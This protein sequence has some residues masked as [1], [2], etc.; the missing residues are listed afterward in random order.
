MG[1]LGRVRAT[2]E[3]LGA[4]P[5]RLQ[6]PPGLQRQTTARRL[7]GVA[8][9]LGRARRLSREQSQSVD[10]Y[11][12]HGTPSSNSW[13]GESSAALALT[14][15]TPRAILAPVDTLPRVARSRHLYIHI[16]AT[17]PHRRRRDR[18]A[19]MCR[20][21]W[22]QRGSGLDQ[23]QGQKES[24]KAPQ[25]IAADEHAVEVHTPT[26]HAG[27]A[28]QRLLTAPPPHQEPGDLLALQRTLGNQGVQR[29]LA[30]LPGR[31]APGAR[32]LS[33]AVQR[34]APPP[35]T[36]VRPGRARAEQIA[37][38]VARYRTT[39]MAGY[40][41]AVQALEAA[42]PRTSPRRILAM[43]R[44][45]YYG[46]PWSESTTEQWR[47]VLPESPDMP[48]PRRSAAVGLYHALRQSQ[49]VDGTD[50]G[51]LLA[52]LEA[53]LNPRRSVELEIPGPNFVVT[54]PNTEFATWGGDLGSAAGQ[55]VADQD[56]NP[57]ARS[58][59]HYFTN[60]VS[61]ADL[62]GNIDAFVIQRGARAS[63]GL[64]AL[65]GEGRPPGSGTPV[66][67]ILRQYYL[68]PDTAMGRAHTNRYRT[69]VGILG[70]RVSGRTITNRTELIMPIARRVSSFARL[71][72]ANEYRHASLPGVGHAGA[73]QTLFAPSPRLL[74]RL[75]E[76]SAAM[77]GLFLNWLQARL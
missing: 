70:G 68:A 40:V 1:Q 24:P 42:H 23:H 48:D 18:P 67:E 65:L 38:D 7:F 77:V 26:T 74:L 39:T 12:R 71:W 52:G 27:A 57:P 29:L 21:C 30:D 63:G 3:E 54:M 31:G 33:P 53:L 58:D 49:V 4:G 8:G 66:S 5:R 10:R 55:E 46:R 73:A 22:S 51:H 14:S 45:F 61:A 34:D 50:V 16:T 36:A 60:M 6:C 20:S 25:P 47:D 72:Y 59:R 56:F 43:L 62:A 69:F 76:K 75:L 15:H 11:A 32:P 17:A 2:Y 44:Q 28:L 35:S 41:R 13:A 19:G 64:A 9:E 37:R